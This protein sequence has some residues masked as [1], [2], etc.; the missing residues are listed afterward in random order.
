MFEF[1]KYW[2]LNCNNPGKY[3][4]ISAKLLHKTNL[5]LAPDQTCDI[6]FAIYSF[7]TFHK[8][9]YI[10]ILYLSIYPIIY[11]PIHIF[12]YLS[13]HLYISIHLSIHLSIQLS[14]LLSIH[15]SIQLSIHLS[16]QLSIQAPKPWN[17]ARDLQTK[18]SR[19]ETYSKH[20][21]SK[22]KHF[23]RG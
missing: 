4:Q 2:D 3:L 21:S 19:S 6:W 22:V 10:L 1:N 7:I 15:L 11:P 8:H 23:L 14:I 12:I 20:S 5:I 16:I 9:N 18:C 13:I 17:K